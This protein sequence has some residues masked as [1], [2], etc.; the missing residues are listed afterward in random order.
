[1][2]TRDLSSSAERAV[3]APGGDAPTLALEGP[4]FAGRFPGKLDSKARVIIPPA[5][6]QKILGELYVFPSLVEPVLQI[7]D[8]TLPDLLLSAVTDIELVDEFDERL[9]QLENY[10]MER[11]QPITMDDAGRVAMPADY[12][13]HAALE[14]PLGFGGR[15]SHF[16]LAA[17][18]YFERMDAEARSLAGELGSI[19]A[20][21]M[22]PRTK[23][24]GGR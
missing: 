6:R 22:R 14:G 18:D 17:A 11:A 12:R 9:T 3:V 19:L 10:V 15:E 21:K 24:R 7:G 1:M 13:Q 20:A 16:V 2:V 8:S 5:F 4:R 23:G